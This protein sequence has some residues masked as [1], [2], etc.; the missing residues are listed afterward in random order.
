MYE[1]NSFNRVGGSTQADTKHAIR[2]FKNA[3]KFIQDNWTDDL[4]QKFFRLLQ[5]IEMEITKLEHRK[6]VLSE[7]ISILRNKLY[8]IASDDADEPVPVKKK[9]LTPTD[10]DYAAGPG[11]FSRGRW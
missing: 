3:S 1:N 5:N 6:V 2:E 11:G 10:G 9:V 8:E 4:G 7:N